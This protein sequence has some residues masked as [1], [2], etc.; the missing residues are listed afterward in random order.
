MKYW[1]TQVWHV[2]RVHF[3]MSFLGFFLFYATGFFQKY[4][5]W[6]LVLNTLIIAVY[7][8][9]LFLEGKKI[10]V[11]DKKTYS[12]HMPYPLKGFV[13]GLL[14][15]IPP[16]LAVLLIY[17]NTGGALIKNSLLFLYQFY[18]A[19]FMFIL[20][21]AGGSFGLLYLLVALVLPVSTGLGYLS[22]LKSFGI[23]DALAKLI[24]KFKLEE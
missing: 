16:L 10:A 15:S 7:A 11:Q 2:W 13:V 6:N 18:F 4:Q 8:T 17:C 22:G 14:T 9:Y 24:G 20:E 12:K 23:Y 5:I 19:S 3:L 1:L 21:K